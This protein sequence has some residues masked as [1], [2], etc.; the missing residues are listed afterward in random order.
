[1]FVRL[2]SG[3]IEEPQDIVLEVVDVFLTNIGSTSYTSTS[4]SE[5]GPS[6]TEYYESHP[7]LM[8][9]GVKMHFMH[10]H[11]N[12]KTF[13]SGE[14]DDDLVINTRDKEVD[15]YTSLIV[16]NSGEWI[17]CIAF[18][19][20]EDISESVTT[21]LWSKL[22]SK[23]PIVNKRSHVVSKLVKL[24][25]IV[26]REGAGEELMLRKKFLE[27]AKIQKWKSA[28]QA[29]S[30]ASGDKNSYP[31][32]DKRS[33]GNSSSDERLQSNSYRWEE[34]RRRKG[35][36]QEIFYPSKEEKEEKDLLADHDAMMSQLLMYNTME[37][38]SFQN[39]VLEFVRRMKLAGWVSEQQVA[40]HVKR[41]TEEASRVIGS[42]EGMHP[43][44]AYVT[45]CLEDLS[46]EMMDYVNPSAEE[47]DDSVQMFIRLLDEV[48]ESRG[49][50]GAY[51]NQEDNGTIDITKE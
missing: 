44:Y 36:P 41:V 22:L 2:I 28:A 20:Q 8:E 18:R 26:E 3:S 14:D 15:F 23:E 16:N 47:Q 48:N 32:Y 17:S 50:S 10:S 46:N 19:I 9:D 39:C 33:Y 12:M 43:S 49:G 38:N 30:I 51:I 5:M 34:E 13:F 21:T 11:H 45:T 40:Y 35:P 7:E 42:F 27:D 37:K 1:M 29:T 4:Y 6:I 24:P 25:L 31:D